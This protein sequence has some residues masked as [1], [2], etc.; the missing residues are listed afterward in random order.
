MSSKYA[1]IFWTLEDMFTVMSIMCIK[2]PRKEV[3]DYE[4]GDSVHVAYKGTLYPGEI[5]A[6]GGKV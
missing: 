3:E 5:L 2:K 1:T 6:L 4:V